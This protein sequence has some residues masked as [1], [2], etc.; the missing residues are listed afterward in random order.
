MGNGAV[1]AVLR[2]PLGRL[3]DGLCEL[4]FTGRRTGRM[5][6]LPVRCAR[7]GDLVVVYVGRAA[8]KRWWW[9]FIDPR[10]VVVRAGGATRAGTGPLVPTVHPDRLATESAYRRRYATVT[11][12]TP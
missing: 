7:D 8:G 3:V 5:V 11:L 9:N 2:S 4:R 6:C 1:L 10:P 12:S